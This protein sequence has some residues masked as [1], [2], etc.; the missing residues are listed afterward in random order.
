MNAN[1]SH[2]TLHD[3]DQSDPIM[4]AQFE[5]D[6]DGSVDIMP[7]QDNKNS[8][9]FGNDEGASWLFSREKAQS[10]I[11]K[12]AKLYYKYLKKLYPSVPDSDWNSS[13]DPNYQEE[14]T[15]A[16]EQF[17]PNPDDK[18]IDPM[19]NKRRTAIAE[20]RADSY[21]RMQNNLPSYGEQL[22]LMDPSMLQKALYPTSEQVIATIA[23]FVNKLDKN[24]LT[25]IKKSMDQDITSGSKELVAYLSEVF[26]IVVKPTIT[27]NNRN[28]ASSARGGY[29]EG[30][31]HIII[32]HFPDDVTIDAIYGAVIHEMWHAHQCNI[33]NFG[34][35]DSTNRRLYLIK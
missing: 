33:I 10:T 12:S 4:K 34:R 11:D 32:N 3:D 25:E 19:E 20:R 7:A 14:L 23:P 16:M 18:P 26:G 24:I 27:I 17:L 9:L 21:I 6:I 31:N 2:E 35:E 28:K 29:E 8:D 30:P 13:S 22:C 15:L 5:E 1:Y